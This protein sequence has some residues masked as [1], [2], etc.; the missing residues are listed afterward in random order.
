MLSRLF[1]HA[2]HAGVHAVCALAAA[3]LVFFYSGHLSLADERD[4]A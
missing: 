4:D 3:S 2:V 1:L